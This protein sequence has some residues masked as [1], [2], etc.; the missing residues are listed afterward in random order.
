F[1]A[2]ACQCMRTLAVV[3][4]ETH[5]YRWPAF[6]F[7]DLTILA[8][9]FSFVVYQGGRLLGDW[10]SESLWWTATPSVSRDRSEGMAHLNVGSLSGRKI[11]LSVSGSIAAYKAPLLLRRLCEAGAT[12]KVIMTSSAEK[13]IGSAVFRGLGAAVYT[14]MW[15]GPGELHVE[16]SAWA[17]LIVVAPATADSLSRMAQGR[18][19][20]LLSATLLCSS[21]PVA[22]A[23]AMHPNMWSHPATKRN[24]RTLAERGVRFLGPVQ[25]EVASGESGTGRMEEP[26]RL[27]AGIVHLLS[28]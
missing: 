26:D 8:Y 6:L 11:L 20:D 22:V 16:L 3:K 5:S 24:A 13:F 12:V 4:R 14:D 28:S 10:P 21:A 1:S 2:R 7:V 25:G 18:A 27:A 9:F 17:D 23:P 15:E 19:D